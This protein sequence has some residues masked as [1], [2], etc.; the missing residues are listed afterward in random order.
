MNSNR[1]QQLGQDLQ[2]VTPISTPIAWL[3]AQPLQGAENGFSLTGGVFNYTADLRFMDS[4]HSA[5][6]RFVFKVRTRK[7]SFKP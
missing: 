3:F 7:Y 4:G 5:Q 6:V 1:I 2:L